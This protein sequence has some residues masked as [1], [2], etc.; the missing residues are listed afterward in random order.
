MIKEISN[1]DLKNIK[2]LAKNDGILFPKKKANYYGYFLN[3]NIIGIG[4]ILISK[5]TAILKCSFVVKENRGKGIATQ[6]LKYRLDLIKSRYKDNK[7]ITANCT[8]LSLQLHI[9]QGAKVLKKYKNGITKVSYE[10][11]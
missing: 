4:A 9:K 2:V 11:L 8:N 1:S 6:L 10:N 5:S 7:K 3:N